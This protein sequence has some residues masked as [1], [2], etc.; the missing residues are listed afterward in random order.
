MSESQ[1]SVNEADA[2]LDANLQVE[3]GDELV[4]KAP[5]AA[6]ARAD[7][8]VTQPNEGVEPDLWERVVGLFGGADSENKDT[9]DEEV[10]A[11]PVDE[12][13]EVVSRPATPALPT[14]EAVDYDAGVISGPPSNYEQPV[15]LG[16][17]RE[18]ALANATVLG[19]EGEL[20]RRLLGIVEQSPA[21]TVA[22]ATPGDE[23]LGDLT[24]KLTE[25]EFELAAGDVD[26]DTDT[27]PVTD[28]APA[29]LATPV[30]SPGP[31]LPPL[32]LESATV[33]VTID[34]ETDDDVSASVVLVVSP[35]G[36]GTVID[37][38]VMF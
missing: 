13:V 30:E 28:E 33:G 6:T 2:V 21:P 22:G 15:Q 32:P 16:Q 25:G 20:I 4:E 19:A 9:G 10:E 34:V 7:S 36:T 26:V 8:T 23:S 17:D 24:V 38:R 37:G 12:A 31:G 35:V 29:L 18:R 14:L 11:E 27:H 3:T 5:I 1:P